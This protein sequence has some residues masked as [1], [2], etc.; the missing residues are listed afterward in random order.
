M[1]LILL[2]SLA[3]AF[4]EELIDA[5]IVSGHCMQND[6]TTGDSKSSLMM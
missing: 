1:T 3:G 4:A 5:Y 6:T 2:F